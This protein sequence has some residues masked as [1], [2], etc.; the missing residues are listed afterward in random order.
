MSTPDTPSTRQWW[1]LVI[2]A[3]LLSSSP[4]TTHISQSGLERSSRW[5]KIRPAS[6]RSWSIEPGEGSAVWR[7]W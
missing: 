2:M 7:T 4:W 5:E 6:W 3:H 1:V